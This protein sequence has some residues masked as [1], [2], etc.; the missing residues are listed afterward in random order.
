L[1]KRGSPFEVRDARAHQDPDV[2]VGYRPLPTL[3][4]AVARRE[5]V[6]LAEQ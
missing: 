5:M 6:R 4:Q 3:N 2:S 1:V